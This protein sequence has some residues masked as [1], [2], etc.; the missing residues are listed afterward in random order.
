[1]EQYA[2]IAAIMQSA[3][4]TRPSIPPTKPTSCPFL[5]LPTEL[6]VRIYEFV[7]AVDY[8][9]GLDIAWN[10]E[11][12][13]RYFALRVGTKRIR[14]RRRH[15]TAL[16][17]T[18]KAT[19]REALNVLLDATTFVLGV[20]SWR[21]AL[22]YPGQ[23][24]HKPTSLSFLK[25]ARKVILHICV[26]GQ[27]DVAP[28][29]HNLRAMLALLDAKNPPRIERIEF[30][31]PDLRAGGADPVIEIL[32]EW[33]RDHSNGLRPNIGGR[34]PKEAISDEVWGEMRKRADGV[35]LWY[36]DSPQRR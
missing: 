23:P 33:F 6:R 2:S 3:Q 35:N 21:G 4:P 7:Y 14:G 27:K 17:L 13:Q 10:T 28:T 31:F 34:L 29:M 26:D 9:C 19:S 16:P 5:T 20:S 12:R 24:V 11:I 36:I 18:C 32:V 25:E 30:N 22:F 8:E 1:M 15:A